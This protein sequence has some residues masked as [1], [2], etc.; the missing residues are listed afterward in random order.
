MCTDPTE[1]QYA[2]E[3]G[4]NAYDSGCSDEANP[5]N[6]GTPDYL[7]WNLGWDEAY[8]AGAGDNDENYRTCAGDVG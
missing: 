3:Q 5:Y 8:K 6:T 4:Q 1:N 2:F 7:A